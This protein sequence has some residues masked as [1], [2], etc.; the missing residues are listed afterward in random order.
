[1]HEI[2]ACHAGVR[3]LF[4][5]SSEATVQLLSYS[6]YKMRELVIFACFL[7]VL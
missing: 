3:D 5:D 4:L 2:N 1:M 7:I 6:T